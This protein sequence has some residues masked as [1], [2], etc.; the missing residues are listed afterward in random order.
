VLDWHPGRQFHEYRPVA[1]VTIEAVEGDE[2]Q[3]IGIIGNIRACLK[4]ASKETEG[5]R[6]NGSRADDYLSLV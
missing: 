6:I 2:A 4:E 3:A 5:R 1:T